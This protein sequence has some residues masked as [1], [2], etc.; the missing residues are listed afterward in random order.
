[1]PQGLPRAG[2]LRRLGALI[3]D[4]FLLA[5]L[6]MVAE[7]VLVM[8]V[9][10]VAMAGL[11]DLSRY[12]DVGAYLTSNRLNTLWLIG[13][14]IAFYTY[15]WTFAGQTLG[16]RAWRLRV[17]NVDGSNVRAIQGLVRCLSAL[18][19]FG[20]VRSLLSSDKLAWQDKVADCEVVLLPKR[21]GKARSDPAPQ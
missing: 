21:Q 8:A 19:G 20:N 1:M 11:L 7:F 16:M 14:I 3:Y 13:W 5:G 10:L 4:W 9:K 15:F 18:L 6:L 12:G 17:Q 2:F